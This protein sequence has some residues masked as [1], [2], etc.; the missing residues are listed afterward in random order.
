MDGRSL[1]EG[2]VEIGY[3]GAWGTVSD[4]Y[5]RW[6]LTAANIVCRMLGYRNASWTGRVTVSGNGLIMRVYKHCT[7]KETSLEYCEYYPNTN[8]D[9]SILHSYDVGVRCSSNPG[10]KCD[11]IE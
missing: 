3:S 5:T 8:F 6:N 1:N 9:A 2:R 11:L 10:E 4:R 7:G